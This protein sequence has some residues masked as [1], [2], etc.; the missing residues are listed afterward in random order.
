[1]LF[2]ASGLAIETFSVSTGCLILIGTVFK[3]LL[4]NLFF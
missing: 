3:I 4:E 1:M 2:L